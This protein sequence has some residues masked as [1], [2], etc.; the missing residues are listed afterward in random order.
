MTRCAILCTLAACQAREPEPCLEGFGRAADGNCYALVGDDTDLPTAPSDTDPDTDVDTDTDIATDTDTATYTP[1]SDAQVVTAEVS[2][3]PG[4]ETIVIRVHIVGWA[5]E[6]RLFMAE[7]A[8]DPAWSEEH[9]LPSLERSPSVG[10]WEDFEL[11]LDASV[12][13]NQFVAGQNSGFGCGDHIEAP[14]V[15]SYAVWV[16]DV[17]Q[18]ADD[19][20]WWGEDPWD[21]INGD[22]A[23]YA[24]FD[25]ESCRLE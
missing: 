23:M 18:A 15:M 2:C 6:A 19:C 25:L 22:L 7:T 10:G 14:G 5:D 16:D 9:V 8:N 1:R 3:D 13:I 11:R 20:L 21:L 24:T 4:G 12:P 17:A